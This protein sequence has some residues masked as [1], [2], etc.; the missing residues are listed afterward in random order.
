MQV[1]GTSPA[2]TVPSP[3]AR[4][5]GKSRGRTGLAHGRWVLPR[6]LSIAAHQVR[7]ESGGQFAPQNTLAPVVVEESPGCKNKPLVKAWERGVTA[8]DSFFLP[9]PTWVSPGPAPKSHLLR[10]LSHTRWDA[11]QTC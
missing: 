6:R 3:C 9:G 2:H 11:G 7:V 5:T 10:P 1:G 4:L 8:G